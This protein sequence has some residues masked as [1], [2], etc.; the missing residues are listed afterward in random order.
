M[1][2]VCV[3][4]QKC[5]WSAAYLDRLHGGQQLRSIERAAVFVSHNGR[6]VDAKRQTVGQIVGLKIT[7]VGLWHCY[8]QRWHWYLQIDPLIDGHANGRFVHH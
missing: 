8:G 6:S 7:A 3:H 2:C 1:L 5:G 4:A